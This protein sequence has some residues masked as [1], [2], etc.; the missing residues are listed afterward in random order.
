MVPGGNVVD[1]LARLR[2]DGALV[3]QSQN[4]DIPATRIYMGTLPFLLADFL[5]VGLLIAFPALAL[6]LPA[7]LGV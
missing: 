1:E 3:I 5:L 4:P 7:K 6:W 2:P